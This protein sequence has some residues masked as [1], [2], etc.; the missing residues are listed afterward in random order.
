MKSMVE[1]IKDIINKSYNDSL[2]N[3]EKGKLKDPGSRGYQIR[4]I[5]DDRVYTYGPN[6]KKNNSE[7]TTVYGF[8]SVRLNRLH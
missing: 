4:S 7:G 5:N 1:E 6:T 3:L 8:N 2:G